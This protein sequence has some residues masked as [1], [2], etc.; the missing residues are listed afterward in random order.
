MRI[1]FQLEDAKREVEWWKAKVF[2]VAESR[3]GDYRTVNSRMSLGRARAA[4]ENQRAKE[5]PKVE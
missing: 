1:E 2:P 5:Q 4:L 3:T